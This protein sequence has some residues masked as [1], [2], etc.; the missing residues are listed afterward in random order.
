MAPQPAL[1]LHRLLSIC[2]SS[3]TLA[4]GH[5]LQANEGHRGKPSCGVE[6]RWPLCTTCARRCSPSMA[7]AWCTAAW[8]P[9]AS[10]GSRGGRAGRWLPVATGLKLACMCAAA[11]SCDMLPL[12]SEPCPPPSPPAPSLPICHCRDGTIPT[13]GTIS[14][15]AIPAPPPDLC[16]AFQ[17]HK[18][19]DAPPPPP[20]CRLCKGTSLMWH[21]A[22]DHVN[23]LVCACVQAVRGV[24]FDVVSTCMTQCCFMCAGS[25]RRSV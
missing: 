16:L 4:A 5:S 12:R 22:S 1:K 10:R 23:P 15:K 17:L 21:V 20:Q 13:K 8:G 11:T 9:S 3:Q 6:C 24:V 2:T 25:A 18:H 14:P 19:M 7:G